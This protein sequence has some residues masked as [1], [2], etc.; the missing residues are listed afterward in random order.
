M[1]GQD[2]GLGA[3]R[4]EKPPVPRGSCSGESRPSSAEMKRSVFIK[5][6]HRRRS[7]PGRRTARRLTASFGSPGRREA[8]GGR[9]S[10]VFNPSV[11][12]QDSLRARSRGRRRRVVRGV[13]N[14]VDGLAGDGASSAPSQSL[15]SSREKLDES[16]NKSRYGDCNR[17]H[18][19]DMVGMRS[20]IEGMG[21]PS[22]RRHRY[23]QRHEARAFGPRRR[24]AMRAG[25]RLG[26]SPGNENSGRGIS[27]TSRFS[28]CPNMGATSPHFS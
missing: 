28:A 27:C 10:C 9:P 21:M 12:R 11:A 15:R 8:A 17:H 24:P 4:G 25:S 6:R 19:Q 2:R 23:L 3:R 16:G 26:A 22:I 18:P 20:Q 1:E 14:V 7:M 5:R 13:R